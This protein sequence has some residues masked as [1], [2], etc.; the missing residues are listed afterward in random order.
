MLDTKFRILSCNQ[1][2]V[3]FISENGKNKVVMR[4]YTDSSEKISFLDLYPEIFL[5][6]N[7]SAL[8]G[9]DGFTVYLNLNT[10]AEKFKS[11]IQDPFFTREKSLKYI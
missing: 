6:E 1:E 3:E 5:P 11:K 8:K 2:F 7:E 10:L 9:R 4:D